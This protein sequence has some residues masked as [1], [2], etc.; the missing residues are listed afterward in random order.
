MKNLKNKRGFTLVE[1]LAVIV[2]LALIMAI[3][4]YSI[5]GILQSSRESVFKETGLNV[6]NGVRNQL[7]ANNELREGNYYFSKALLENDND[8]PFGGKINYATIGSTET[9]IGSKV[10]DIYAVY[11]TTATVSCS[12]TSSSYVNVKYENGQFVYSVCLT[13]DEI[14][15]ATQRFIDNATEA[16]LLGN[17]TD[18]I[19]AVVVSE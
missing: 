11:R 17:T 2:I 9:G 5:S 1:L 13:P 14:T 3:A 19:K 6:L 4:I 16:E 15:S 10:G 18:K 12:Q 8:L 7:M